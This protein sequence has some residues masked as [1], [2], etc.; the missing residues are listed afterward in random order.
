MSITEVAGT[1]SGDVFL[2]GQLEPEQPA[3]PTAVEVAPDPG[4]TYIRGG[5]GLQTTDR[6]VGRLTAWVVLISMF[7]WSIALFGAAIRHDNQVQ[8]LHDHGVGVSATASSCLALASGTGATQAGFTCK[9][10]YDFRGK[11]YTEVIHN[12]YLQFQ[13]GQQIATV[14]DPAHPSIL[15]YAAG[16]KN[17]SNLWK[18]YVLPAVLLIAFVVGT[19]WM[20]TRRRRDEAQPE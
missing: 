8:G 18:Q 10:S 11:H 13:P 12:T 14:V 17:T 9:A 2:G 6:K 20:I 16:V 3:E 1:V 4:A 19:A 5:G 15:S 7:A